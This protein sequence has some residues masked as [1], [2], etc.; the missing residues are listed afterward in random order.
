MAPLE[1]IGSGWS[2]TG[3]AAMREALIDLG[4]DVHHMIVIMT[5]PTNDA[6]LF[7]RA[8]DGE[9]VDWD[10]AYKNFNAAVDYPTCG[11]Y[12]E[13]MQKYPN[14][15]VLHTTR[16]PEQ[17]YESAKK[18]IYTFEQ[19]KPPA[20]APEHV[21]VAAKMISKNVWYGDFQGKFED[22]EATI[23]LFKEHDEEVKRTVPADRL[24][25]FETGVDG[26][27]KLCTFLGK[28]IPNKPWPHINTTKEFLVAKEKITLGKTPPNQFTIQHT[29]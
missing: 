18:T 20:E 2:R 13:L 9:D 24:L 29:N 23:K 16:D 27:E 28:D 12:K 10:V 5:D 3:T 21:K 8:Y 26:W 14:A 22:K 11:F 1:V 4:Y 6:A 19:E 15:K 17:W 7:E 25:V